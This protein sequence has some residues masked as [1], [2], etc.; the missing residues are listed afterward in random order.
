MP[1]SVVYATV[2]G[3]LV[4]ENR[5]GVVTRYVPDTLGSVIQTRDAA[6]NQSSSTT[7]WPFG[8]VRASSG[9]NPSPWGFCGT[10]GYFKDATAR[11]Y[12]RARILR[13][14]LSKWM[15]V[16]PL[17]PDE[18]PYTYARGNPTN[19]VDESGHAVLPILCAGA[20]LLAAGC[21]L[22]VWIACRNWQGAWDSF[23]ECAQ[24]YIDSL[25]PISKIGCAVGI[26]GCLA[27]LAKAAAKW[28]KANRCKALG[29]AYHIA[30]P[31][32]RISMYPDVKKCNLNDSC[33][34]VGFKAKVWA[35]CC[36]A[37]QALVLAKCPDPKPIEHGKAR[38][39]A[40]ANAAECAARWAICTGT[41]KK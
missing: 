30:C 35:G 7:Y 32:Y 8:E 11:F 22:G 10:W 34:T 25:P 15:T 13:A 26:V 9:N 16:D 29:V 18:D 5:G 38:R 2:N 17:W 33:A 40:C 39:E 20:C 41:C 23:G 37:R 36:A 4:Q 31:G 14:D 3:R 1:M 6:G 27:C 24:D 19:S 21:A 28:I 12:V